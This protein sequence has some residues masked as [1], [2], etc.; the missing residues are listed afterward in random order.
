MDPRQL[1][2]YQRSN[3]LY[4]TILL[5]TRE[6]LLENPPSY[7]Q[8]IP[9]KEIPNTNKIAVIIDPRY[10]E[11]MEAVILN[12][13]HFMVP[14]GWIFLIGSSEQYKE[15]IQ[16][17]FPQALFITIDNHLLYYDENQIPNLTIDNYNAI[18]CSPELWNKIPCEYIAVFQKDC[19]M[20]RMFT[21]DWPIKY[22]YSGA[23]WYTG[24][25]SL[26]NGVINGG[27]SLRKKSA[28][29]N[30]IEHITWEMIELYRKNIYTCH[31]Y[32]PIQKKN[33]DMFFTY[34]CE[35][36]QY[37]IAPISIRKQ[38]AIES[39]YF[40]GT[41][42]FHGWNK[43]GYQIEDWA[44]QILSHSPLFSKYLPEVLSSLTITTSIPEETPTT[45]PQQEAQTPT[46]TSTLPMFHLPDKSVPEVRFF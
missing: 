45:I 37:P 24:E 15:Q 35:I 8:P 13:M 21:E 26:A 38:L 19:I 44:I 3:Q 17:R 27:F 39:E 16:Q 25:T 1:E 11:L 10:D 41:S 6:Q 4:K 5:K 40:L 30:C 18:F 9:N 42:V 32:F 36:L 2:S 33:E 29:L 20:Y 31:E 12:F 43:A 22:A 28:M 23:F 46:E 34:A 7:L 14:E